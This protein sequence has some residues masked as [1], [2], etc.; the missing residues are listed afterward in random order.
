MW[1]IGNNF[2]ILNKNY[3]IV[4]V[5]VNFV[6]LI[7]CFCFIIWKKTEVQSL[8]QFKENILLLFCSDWSLKLLKKWFSINKNKDWFAVLEKLLFIAMFVIGIIS[9]F[10]L[11][12]FKLKCYNGV[13]RVRS[14]Y[15][16][17]SINFLFRS[18]NLTQP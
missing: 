11:V 2:S 4:H 7:F 1:A 9:I 8:Y 15:D 13:R 12:L 18:R 17:M 5:L 3:F 14:N 6:S 10:F 16:F